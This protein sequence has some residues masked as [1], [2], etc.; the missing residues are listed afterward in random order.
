M[1][2]AS[3][4]RIGHFTLPTQLGWMAISGTER[5]ISQ[6]TFGHS[7]EPTAVK[8]LE[9]AVPIGHANW[10]WLSAVAQRLEQYAAGELVDFA[11]IPVDLV[12][13][14]PFQEEVRVALRKVPYGTTISYLDLS[15]AAGRPRAAR[16]VGGVM[17]RNPVP[18]VL[19]CHRVTGSYG[20]LG[21][22]SAPQG[23]EMKR[24]LLAMEEST[25]LRLQRSS[26][27]GN[28]VTE[29]A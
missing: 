12:A 29:Q 10:D 4:G 1:G 24:R 25:L 22:Y 9:D 19:P 15:I 3:L 2:R 13:G 27:D 21:G 11:D 20:N 23:L 28:V 8:A 7:K 16:A 26:G 5:G 6:L 18:L 17:A 14:T